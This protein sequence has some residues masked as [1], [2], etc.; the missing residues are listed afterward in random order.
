[1]KICSKH[2]KIKNCIR[3]DL[4]E[5]Y[6]TMNY[7]ISI[8]GIYLKMQVLKFQT[9]VKFDYFLYIKLNFLLLT[10]VRCHPINKCQILIYQL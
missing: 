2:V 7:Y 1:M 3:L 9:N 10:Y 6:M 4:D 8:K 5:L